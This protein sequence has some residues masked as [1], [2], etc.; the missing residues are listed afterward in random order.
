MSNLDEKKLH[1]QVFKKAPGFTAGSI[2]LS[3]LLKLSAIII[4]TF[5]MMSQYDIKQFWW[6]PVIAI[7]LFVVYPIY[8]N[9]QQFEKGLKEAEKEMLCATCRH[10]NPTGVTCIIFD[11]HV[12][13]YAIPCEGQSWEPSR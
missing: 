2:V 5:L 8:T 10:Y 11:E 6:M 4:V 1:P 3:A 12:T 13:P 9:Y 7:A